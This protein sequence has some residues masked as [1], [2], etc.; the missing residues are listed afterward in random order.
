MRR[1]FK[2][3]T[4]VELML[5]LGVF[6]LVMALAGSLL[7]QGLRTQR[8]MRERFFE[9]RRGSLAMDQLSREM[10]I[11]EA[12]YWPNLTSWAG[13]GTAYDVPMHANEA[14]SGF[15]FG[16]RDHGSATY[17]VTCWWL[18]RDS[19]TLRNRLCDGAGNG[20]TGYANP[21]GHEMSGRVSD[22][23]VTHLSK[24][25]PSFFKITLTLKGEEPMER[26]V[27][28]KSIW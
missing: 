13:P 20:L 6:S 1:R 18:D 7:V 28:V 26:I 8:L 17:L 22:F 19:G 16:R 24:P 3:L 9:L 21:S 15:Q 25:N 5:A 27:S 10:Q 23:T 4:M 12:I 11:C 14:N 2:A